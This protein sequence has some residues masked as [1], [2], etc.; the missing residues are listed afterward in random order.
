MPHLM[1]NYGKIMEHTVAVRLHGGL[2]DHLLGMRLLAFIRRRYSDYK[3]LVYSDCGGSIAQLQVAAMSPYVADVIPIFQDQSRVTM[4]SLGSLDN[5]EDHSISLMRRADVFI[6]GWIGK[7]G[8]GLYF[9]QSKLLNV[10]YYIILAARPQLNIPPEAKYSAM[11]LLNDSTEMKYIA[12]N[13]TKYGSEFIRAITP[14]LREFLLSLLEDPRVYVLNIFSRTFDFPHW[15]EP[16]RSERRARLVEESDFIAKLCEW[17]DRILPVVDEGIPT[18]AALVRRCSYFI[19]V[20]NGI[21]HLAWALDVPITFLC[22][23]NPDR[24]FI[25]RWVPDLNN[26]LTVTNSTEIDIAPLLQ[27]VRTALIAPVGD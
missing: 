11:K 6:D 14:Y 8:S 24:E 26:L 19:G 21:K 27:K 16:N 12:I 4:E 15:P 1:S 10:P 20:D 3:I 22:L 25:L 18:I 9:D 7:W 13:F 17:S 2:G 23:G 5:I